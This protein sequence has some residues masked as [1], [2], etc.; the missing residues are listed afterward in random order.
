MHA[1]RFKL[2]FFGLVTSS[3]DFAAAFRGSL[4]E[5]RAAMQ[6]FTEDRKRIAQQVMPSLESLAEIEG[7]DPDLRVAIAA[8][9]RQLSKVA[10]AD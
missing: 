6:Q 10:D 9:M 4:Q 1:C 5:L 8:S 2:A 3:P 7:L